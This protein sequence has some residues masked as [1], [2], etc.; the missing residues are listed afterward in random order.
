M[1]GRTFAPF[2]VV[3]QDLADF[4][5]GGLCGKGWHVDNDSDAF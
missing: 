5:T 4:F 3:R 1:V 2:D